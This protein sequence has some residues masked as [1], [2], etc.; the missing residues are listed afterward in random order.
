MRTAT[1]AVLS[2]VI[3]GLLVGGLALWLKPPVTSMIVAMLI[4]VMNGSI[5]LLVLAEQPINN[6]PRLLVGMLLS[7]VG[8]GTL[9]M[10]AAQITPVLAQLLFVIVVY[11]A[12]AMRARP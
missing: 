11:V 5:A 4:T 10:I 3:S 9:S 12:L 8:V 6:L 1:R 2:V 7:I